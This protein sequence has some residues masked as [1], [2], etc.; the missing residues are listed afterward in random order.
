MK[1][2]TKPLACLAF[3]SG[4]M[5]AMPAAAQDAVAPPYLMT[6][7]NTVTI[8]VSW[9]LA[10]LEGLLPMGVLAA[11]DLS[12]GINIYDAEGGYGLTPYSAAYAYVNVKGWN[13]SD[14]SSAR[15]ILGGWYGPDPKVAKAMQENFY[16][17]VATGDASQSEDGDTWTGVGGDGTGEIKLVVKPGTDCVAAA[18]MLNYVGEPDGGQGYDLMKVPFT[19]DFCPAEPVSVDISGTG[20]LGQIKVD[21]MLGGGRLRSGTFAFTK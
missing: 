4:A 21:Q 15:F 3:A 19:G 16:A 9:D 5:L 13:A 20:A 8:A 17:D 2:I 10:S 7:A 1:I 11:D 14:G 6:G 18:G 12:G